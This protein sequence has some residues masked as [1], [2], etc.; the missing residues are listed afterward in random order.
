MTFDRVAYIRTLYNTSTLDEGMLQ[1]LVLLAANCDGDLRLRTRSLT[2]QNIADRLHW[3]IAR[4]RR[5]MERLEAGKLLTTVRHD[6]HQWHQ[7][8]TEDELACYIA[9]PNPRRKHIHEKLAQTA[10]VLSSKKVSRR[11]DDH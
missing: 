1:V 7:L 2:R 6:L 4:V 11:R 5:A 10:K 3:G 9:P 8:P